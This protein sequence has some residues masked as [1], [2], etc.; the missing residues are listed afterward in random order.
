MNNNSSMKIFANNFLMEKSIAMTSLDFL[1][2]KT[3]C[4][5]L[6]I[7]DKNINENEGL[8]SSNIII[9]SERPINENENE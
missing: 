4:N 6:N 2:E 1:D 9:V 8:F 5:T 3:V 7:L